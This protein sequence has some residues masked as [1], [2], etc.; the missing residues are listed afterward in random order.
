ME[1]HDQ[2]IERKKRLIKQL[3]HDAVIKAAGSAAALFITFNFIFGKYLFESF[4]IANVTFIEFESLS[5]D[6]L[7]AIKRLLL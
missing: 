4:C 1:K 7:H 3:R 5:R 2:E 6:F